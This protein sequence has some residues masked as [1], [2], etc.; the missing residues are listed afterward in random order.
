MV[1]F[2]FVAFVATFVAAIAAVIGVPVMAQ[3]LPAGVPPIAV[4]DADSGLPH[5]DG[6]AMRERLMA[7]DTDH[8]GKFSKAEWLAAGRKERG[9]DMMDSNHDGY[10]TI[11]ELRAGREKM[12]AMRDAKGTAQ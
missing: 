7:M 12:R 3:T 8:D 5:P 9:F 10:V 2:L 11:D 1:R 6:A 4:P